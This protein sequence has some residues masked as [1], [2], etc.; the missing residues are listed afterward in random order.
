MIANSTLSSNTAQ[1]G[2]AGNFKETGGDGS[3]YGGGLFNLNGTVTLTND[4]FAGNSA[5][6][7]TS[8]GGAGASDGGAVYNLAITALNS[9]GGTSATA[10][11]TA[12]ITVANTIFSHNTNLSSQADLANNQING[13]ATI[14][15][16][17]PN[18]VSAAVENTD[19]T[20]SGTT[21]MVADPQLG[22]LANNGGLTQT[23]LPQTGSPAIGA[24]STAVLTAANFGGAVPF[25]DQRGL[26]YAR[27]VGG[28]VDIGAVEVQP[29][30][31]LLVSGQPN[32]TVLVYTLGAN[33]QYNSS[34]TAT[35][36][37]FG[38]ITTDV[39]TAVGDV[40]GDGIPDYIFATGPGTELEVTVLSGASGNPVL[41]APFD[42]FLPAPPLAQTD[43]F[44]AGGFVSAGD[45]LGNGR[46]QI[47]VSPDQSG[48]PRIAI[49]DMNGAAAATA[50]PYTAIGVNTQE[51]NPGSGLTRINNFISVNP[52]FRGGARTA[53]GDL[54]GD[55]VPDLAIAAGFGGGPAVLVITG[56]QVPTTDGFTASDDL[57]GDFFAFDPSL[58]DGAYL[59]IGDVLGNGQQDLI[60]APGAGGPA[61]VEVLSGMQLLND[62]A[63]AAI[64]NPVALF[65]PIG[66]GPD[67]SGLRVAAAASGVGDQVNVVVG[68]GRNMPGLAKVYPS[69]GFTSGSTSE[70]TGSELLNPFGGAILTD[71]IFVG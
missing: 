22:A 3:G 47:V 28:A 11:Q 34:P 45:F 39:R 1:G 57:I 69:S 62:G 4:T 43:V 53:V 33:G 20:V 10:T 25:T 50:Q 67:G 46:D 55:G 17:G 70:P 44:S 29:P 59:A 54:N 61:E 63:L 58:R 71:G 35:L 32:G 19:G 21:F 23:L 31:P 66:L 26:G 7:G 68:A 64:A 27:V 30:Q 65:T 40:N 8:F 52:D 14:D 5:N 48:G 12:T 18:I 6:P 42:P 56:T 13:T 16:T 2:S 9:V 24:G 38:A 37:P 49:Y 36:Q 60:L 51:I 41:V 15:A